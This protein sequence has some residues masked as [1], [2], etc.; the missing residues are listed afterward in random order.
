MFVSV[1]Q[2]QNQGTFQLRKPDYCGNGKERSQSRQGS[3]LNVIHR[4]Q[5]KSAML[6]VLD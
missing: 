6:L 2:D 3:N 4:M 5:S 1:W